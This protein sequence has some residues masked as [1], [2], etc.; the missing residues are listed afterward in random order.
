MTK[1]SRTVWWHHFI[2][3]QHSSCQERYSATVFHV[4]VSSRCVRRAWRALIS[5]II[6]I[7]HNS[8]QMHQTKLTRPFR[9]CEEERVQMFVFRRREEKSQRYISKADTWSIRWEWDSHINS[10]LKWLKVQ[11]RLP[12]ERFYS[13]YYIHVFHISAASW[14]RRCCCRRFYSRPPRQ[15]DWFHIKPST[16]DRARA[17]VLRWH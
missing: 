11:K 2:V 14:S 15:T 12:A 1:T 6:K 4:F 3:M 5:F 13:I 10:L 16:E 8:T 9:S 17:E 7:I